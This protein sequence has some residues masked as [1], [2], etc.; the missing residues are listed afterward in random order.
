MICSCRCG[1]TSQA[2]ERYKR[3]LNESLTLGWVA[4]TRLASG[5]TSIIAQNILVFFQEISYTCSLID[6]EMR[7]TDRADELK[8]S[9][10]ETRTS[11]THVGKYLCERVMK[12]VETRRPKLL[13]CFE[14]LIY[15]NCSN[16][17]RPTL[18]YGQCDTVPVGD[19]SRFACDFPGC[20]KSYKFKSGVRVHKLNHNPKE[21]YTC[22]W[23]GCTKSFV[24]DYNS[25]LHLE[26]TGIAVQEMT[27][28]WMSRGLH[29]NLAPC[30][31]CMIS[32]TLA[33]VSIIPL[34]E[35]I[36]KGGLNP[37]SDLGMDTLADITA[38]PCH[39]Q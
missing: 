30:F 1:Q 14:Q 37:L 4:N 11:Q 16:L 13:R 26:Y 8:K 36:N 23:P 6:R 20:D 39:R 7:R 24:R 32:K 21:V 17:S 28:Q 3:L 9:L 5:L 29:R 22:T 2:P 27:R 19:E 12:L 25:K 10:I 18:S 31:P 38:N 15:H 35:L 34:R 33:A